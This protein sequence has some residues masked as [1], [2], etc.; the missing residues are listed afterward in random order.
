MSSRKPRESRRAFGTRA[1]Q[2][3]E[4]FLRAHGVGIVARNVHLRYAEIDLVALDGSA[5]CIVEVRARR[6]DR[7]G[8]AAESIGARKRAR[9]LR[10]A[11]ELLATHPLP[12]HSRVRFD[13]IAIDAAREPPTLEWLRDAFYSS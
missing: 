12:R 4:S 11:A 9:L 2:L 6:G 5:L 3:A 10:A 8:S 7:F 1:E 13:V